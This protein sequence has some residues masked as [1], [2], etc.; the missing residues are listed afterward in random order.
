LVRLSVMVTFYLDLVEVSLEDIK[1]HLYGSDS[2]LRVSHIILTHEVVIIGPPSVIARRGF[3]GT[4]S[5]FA[6]DEA[7]YSTILSLLASCPLENET[8]HGAFPEDLEL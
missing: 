3:I 7:S 5:S 6:P 1:S 4:N 2:V 8:L